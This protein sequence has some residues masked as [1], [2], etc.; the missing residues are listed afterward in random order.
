MGV[1]FADSSS[2]PL[3][4]NKTGVA[5]VRRGEPLL[6]VV[7]K[8]V[9]ELDSDGSLFIVASEGSEELKIKAGSKIAG[10]QVKSL[11]KV[12]IALR[13]PIPASED[14]EDWE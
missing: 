7:D 2:L 12:L 6:L 4:S 13:P 10:S 3:Q 11:G 8:G 5:K 9:T 1:H 14:Q